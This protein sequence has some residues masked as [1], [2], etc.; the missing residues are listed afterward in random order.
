MS[1]SISFKSTGV[2]IA[3]FVAI[4][5][6]SITAVSKAR[7]E[8]NH[9]KVTI[10]LS[11]SLGGG[12][13][14]TTRALS[15]VWS[16][17][18]GAK[19]V[20]LPKGGASGRIGYDY[21]LSQPQDGTFILS[22]NI[23]TT[24]TMYVQQKPAWIWKDSI[25]FLGSIAVDPGAIFVLKDSPYKSMKDVIAL[26][27]KPRAVIALSSWASLEN[28]V[29]HQIM[30]QTDTKYEVIPIGGGSDLV[31][32]VL[33]GHVPVGFGK[34]ANINKAS[35]RVRILAVSL[36]KNPV[37]DLTS[38]APTLD[39]AAETETIAVASYRSILIP[40]SLKKKYPDRY[41]KL[42]DSF[43]AA[44]DDPEFIKL[45]KK[46]GI[47][48]SLILD[49]N[50]AELQGIV[51]GIWAAFREHGGFFKEKQKATSVTAK[52]LELEKKGRYVSYL[53]PDGKKERIRV[54]REDSG[55]TINGEA[56]P[57]KKGQKKLKVGMTCT[58]TYVG[59]AVKALSADCKT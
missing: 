42:K 39:K 51:D 52:I 6:M 32:A 46:V 49:K 24:A 38:N 34:V 12:Q 4:A 53:G 28:L 19:L 13:D 54:H 20:V 30:T 2:A 36:P 29:I 55:L 10:V 45:A 43:E 21:F 56:E 11:H 18:F 1:N 48:P 57:G 14:R 17:H 40:A 58:F 47:A 26:G 23:A 5:G 27:K 59:V 8:W 37:K 9:K 33:G 16:K 3:A 35:D 15:K 44:K 7:A 31:T 50:A 25:D 22:T 41:K